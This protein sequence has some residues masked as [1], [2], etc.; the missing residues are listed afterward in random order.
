MFIAKETPNSIDGMTSPEGELI[1]FSNVVNMRYSI[2]TWLMALQKE[3]VDMVK[4]II[5]EGY[6]DSVNQKQ[7]TRILWILNHKSQS[8]T[9][10]NQILWSHETQE[11]I[12]DVSSKSDSL[13]CWY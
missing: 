1:K 10:C 3:M 13:Y 8:V 7:K 6:Q 5:R 9:T 11:A 4:K 2:E 12:R